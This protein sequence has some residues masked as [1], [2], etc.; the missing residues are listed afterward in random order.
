M[1]IEVCFGSLL[2]MLML[3]GLYTPRKVVPRTLDHEYHCYVGL[4]LSFASAVVWFWCSSL[5]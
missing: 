4:S 2:E 5:L 1:K 3:S